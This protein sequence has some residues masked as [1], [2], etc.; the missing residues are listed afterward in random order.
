MVENCK[1]IKLGPNKKNAKGKSEE[2]VFKRYA[3]SISST[4]LFV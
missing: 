1:R 4:A 3:G 2:G